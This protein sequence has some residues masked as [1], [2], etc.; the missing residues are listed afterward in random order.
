M[1]G[2]GYGFHG[3]GGEEESQ[4]SSNE[5]SN[6]DMRVKDVNCGEF[7]CLSVGYKQGQSRKSSGADGK[8]LADGSGCIAHR[9][10]LV[11]YIPDVFVQTSHLSDSACVVSDR[12]VS[13]NGNGDSS[14]GQ[15]AY[16]CQ[17]NSVKAHKLVGNQNTHTYQ[18]DGDRG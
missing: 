13:V 2:L 17:G 12:T 9:V 5:K 7:Y 14:G 8:T 10:Q 16:G 6:N 11:S 18:Q 1:G 15:H 4:H 3:H